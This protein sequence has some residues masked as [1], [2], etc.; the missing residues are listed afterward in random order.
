MRDI[1]SF[2]EKNR[3][4]I[5]EK[6]EGKGKMHEIVKTEDTK[7]ITEDAMKLKQYIADLYKLEK[8]AYSC[9]Q[10]IDELST[11][12]SQMGTTRVEERHIKK[13]GIGL[14]EILAAFG[15]IALGYLTKAF[16]PIFLKII[17]GIATAIAGLIFYLLIDERSLENKKIDKENAQNTVDV[18]NDKVRIKQ[19]LDAIPEKKQLLEISKNNLNTC[20]N[21]LDDL[22]AENII[23][24][25]YRNL[26]AIS[27]LYEYLECGRCKELGGYEGAYN[28]YEQELRMNVIISKLEDIYYELDEI[29]ENQYM[30]YD[31]ICQT[32]ALLS[33]ISS[34]EAV[35]AYNTEVIATNTEIYN[36]YYVY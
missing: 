25:K 7:K 4:L 21:L 6:E 23:F 5:I 16:I 11:Y 9:K 24:P 22:Y 19:E 30:L 2:R 3:R 34:S 15:V 12:I 17:A 31:A 32:N 27:Q 26:P 8:N 33:A 20:Q 13:K 35:T 14:Y 18:E 10:E 1:T 28:L 36:R 29:R